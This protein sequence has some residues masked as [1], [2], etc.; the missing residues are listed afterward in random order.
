MTPDP[1]PLSL[2][3]KNNYLEWRFRLKRLTM[4]WE[5]SRQCYNIY[6]IE[7]RLEHRCL[8]KCFLIGKYYVSCLWAP[9]LVLT[10][11]KETV[12]WSNLFFFYNKSKILTTLF[13]VKYEKITPH[14]QQVFCMIKWGKNKQKQQMVL[15]LVLSL[16]FITINGLAYNVKVM[17]QLFFHVD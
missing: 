16:W 12:S 6:S 9:L 10:Q 7:I 3:P 11:S 15:A 14:N 2:K 5:K 13:M 4:G 1:P 17:C 8:Q